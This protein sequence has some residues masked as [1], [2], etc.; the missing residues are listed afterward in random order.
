MPK[1]SPRIESA[2]ATL[3]ECIE[4]FS[5][6]NRA[7]AYVVAMRWPDGEIACPTC[8]SH[9]VR[10]ISTRRVWQCSESHVRRQFSVKVGTVMEDSP[11]GLDKWLC[12]FWLLAN[13]KNGISSY[14]LARDLDITQKSAWFVL[15][16]VRLAMQEGSIL[17]LGGEGKE[18]EIDETFIGGKARTM[19]ARQRAK[20]KVAP[21]D[22]RSGKPHHRAYTATGK[23]IV[24]GMLE[25]GGKVVTK[26]VD[27]RRRRSM[28]PAIVK[29]VA[30][31]T[32][33]HT[34]ELG[35]YKIF[36]ESYS[37]AAYEHKVIDHTVAYVDGNIHTNNIENFWSLLKRGLRGTYISVEP[38]HL[39]RYLDEQAFRF[40]ARQG[41][42]QSRFHAVLAMVAGKRLTYKQ[43]TG[44]EG[45]MEGHPA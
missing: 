37:P 21:T 33:V 5:D 1:K 11:I 31:K 18:V 19:N 27:S 13:C 8:G 43:L 40:N 44:I 15:H 38:F 42:D 4:Y 32:E 20:S 3:K 26:V 34:D 9:A 36:G 45:A 25:R 16:R 14:E 28:L 22:P 29:H 17:K 2:P 35:S 24:M 39:F 30:P 41:T 12:A 23:A 10:Y 6:P 7:L